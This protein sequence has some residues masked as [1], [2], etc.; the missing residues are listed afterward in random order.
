M[1]E[2][3][4]ETTSGQEPSS[5][6]MAGPDD[7]PKPMDAETARR[8]R[9]G[10]LVIA[11]SIVAFIVVIFFVTIIRLTSNLAERGV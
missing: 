4:P 1:T 7:M 2:T 8:R 9:S 6:Y 3:R 11:W 10:N 5:R